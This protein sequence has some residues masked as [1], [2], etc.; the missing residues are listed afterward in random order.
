MTEH[1]RLP[2]GELIPLADGLK[3]GRSPD[4]AVSVDDPSVSREHAVVRGRPGRWFVEDLGSR[5]GTRVNASRLVFGQAYPLR[6]DDRVLL[7]TVHVVVLS[8]AESDDADRTSS[9]EADRAYMA[10]GLSPFQHQVVVC[11]A[12]PWLAGGEP[13]NNADI[14]R[15]LG[16]PDAVDAI[17]AALRRVY[18]KAGLTED[19]SRTKR[20]E[21]CLFAQ[22]QG[23]L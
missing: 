5:N 10:I 17:K 23:W 8:A 1:L 14:A 12:E 15:L 22:R 4:C 18:A 7:G 6:H 21:L 11:L 9:L 3:L 19:R 2:S 16:T 13:A 20:R